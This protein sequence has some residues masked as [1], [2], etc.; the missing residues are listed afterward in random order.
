MSISQ[1]AARLDSINLRSQGASCPNEE[2]SSFWLSIGQHA[3]RY[4]QHGKTHVGQ[5][6]FRCKE[7]GQTFSCGPSIRKQ[8]RPGLNREVLRM[9]VNKVP[10]RR[11]CEVLELNPATLYSKLSYLAEAEIQHASAHEERLLSESFR[12]QHAYISADRQDYL[13]LIRRLNIELIE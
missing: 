4:Y 10:M 2:C 7:C 12:L 6:R 5:P 9:I 1:E 13:L 11:I 8:K 3:D